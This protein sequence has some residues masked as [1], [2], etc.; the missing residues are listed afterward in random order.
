MFLKYIFL[1]LTAVSLCCLGG[2]GSQKQD[3]ANEKAVVMVLGSEPASL[4]PAL[5]TGLTESTVELELFEGLT[6]LDE[7]SQPQPALAK[8]WSISPDGRTY[9]FKLREGICWSD[10][11]PI[12]AEDFVYAW[13]RVLNPSVG[14]ENAYMLYILENAEDYNSEK[15]SAESVG[16]R[17]PD[18]YTL[19]VRLHDPAAYFLGLTAFHAFYP[20]PRALAEK[21]PETWAG[22]AK[23]LPSCGPYK[24]VSWVHSSEIVLEKNPHYWNKDAVVTP[25][26][27]FPIS[28][29]QSTR[30]TMVESGLAQMTSDPP[31]P[32][33]DRLEKNGLYRTA[34]LLGTYYYVF[35]VTKPPFDDIRVRRA[36]ALAAERKD[37]IRYIVR[38][39]K[40]PALAF[41]PPGMNEGGRDFRIEGG[42]LLQEDAAAAKKLL[43]EAGQLPPVT[44]LYN[45]SEINKAIAEALQAMWQKNLGISVELAN[46]EKKVFYASRLDGDYQLACANWVADFADPMNFLEV[47]S[48]PENDA[49][50]HSKEYDRLVQLAQQEADADRRQDLMHQAE[51]KLFDD[52]VIMPIYF[53]TTPYVALPE[54]KGFYWLPLGTVDLSRAYLEEKK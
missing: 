28:D 53:A 51:Q 8:S 45:T 31:S 49:Q 23:G 50:Y 12:T 44:L 40:E 1:L 2:C 42:N 9:T 34:P 6:R 46:Q 32:D 17:A 41:V 5:T 10:G 25:Q 11:T 27:R 37:L 38:S 4:D 43:A 48:D 22:K 35:N 39:H 33:Q 47:F 29:A 26:L 14:S 15:A 20:V 13:R 19:E 18:K 3:A 52:C 24:I 7:K 16:V 21:E 54:L 36:F 30:L